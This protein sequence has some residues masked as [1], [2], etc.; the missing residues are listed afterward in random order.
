[1]KDVE[2]AENTP[3]VSKSGQDEELKELPESTKKEQLVSGLAVVSF[4]ASITSI[5]FTANPIV[6]VSGIL[7]AALSPYAAVQQ[8][9]ITDVDALSQTTERV[10]EEVEQLKAE[11][12]KLEASVKSLKASN[13]SLLETKKKLDTLKSVEGQSLDE[14]EKQL[15]ESRSILKGMKDDLAGDVMQNIMTVVLAAD[16]N[17]DMML[18]DDEIDQVVKSLESL[19]GVDINDEN[20]RALIIAKGRDIPGLMDVVKTVITADS[21]DTALVTLRGEVAE[22]KRAME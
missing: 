11:N 17:G 15:E 12:L 6:Y 22:Y 18:S 7:G 21:I 19:N 14:L 2:S 20:A 10:K 3:L 16:D 5:I 8:R 1:V 4:A 9:K 13:E